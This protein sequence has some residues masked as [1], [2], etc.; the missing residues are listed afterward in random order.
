MLTHKTLVLVQDSPLSEMFL[1]SS[2]CPEVDDALARAALGK[3]KLCQLSTGT[4]SERLFSPG[5]W[6]DYRKGSKGNLL[7]F[8]GASCL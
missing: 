3:S 7:P 4:L 6:L 2:G 1:V 5:Q 8:V